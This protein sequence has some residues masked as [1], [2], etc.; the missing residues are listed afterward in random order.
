MPEY[1]GN[2]SAVERSGNPLSRFRRVFLGDKAFYSRVAAIV[3]PV[4]IQSSVT[5][6]VNLLDN[7]MVGQLGT[8][9]VSGVAIA[10]QLVFLYSLIIFGALSGPS[11]YG[12]QFYGAKNLDGYRDCFRLK[13]W[14]SFILFA[15]YL[16]VVLLF[17][18]PLIRLFLRGDGDPALAGSILEYSKDYLMWI[19]PALLPFALS[20]SYASTLREAGE[21]MLPMRASLAAVLVNLVFNYLLIFG[22]LGFPELGVKGAAIATMLARVVELVIIAAAAHRKKRYPYLKGLYKRLLVPASLVGSVMSTSAPLILNE[23]LWAL[24]IT[25]LNQIYSM[26]ALHVLAAISIASTIANLFNVFYVSIGNAVAVMVGQAL[27]AGRMDRA[28]SYAWKLIFLATAMCL[29][30]GGIMAALSPVFPQ[31]YNTEDKVRELV[32]GFILIS[33]ALMPAVAISHTA[34]YILRSGGSTVITFLYDAV[35]NWAVQVPLAFL[36]VKYTDFPILAVYAMAEG[37]RLF[38]SMLG[39]LMVRH[40]KWQQQIVA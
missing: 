5:N 3:I 18:E 24:A 11:I 26:R 36:L 8:A 9:Q 38:K 29:V 17:H 40:G 34:Y 16:G 33:S 21:T 2:R 13:L 6:F 1:A 20:M 35:F 28:R 32:T 7:I 14:L 23:A 37:A 31:F 22:E 19:L 25:A 30:I 15:L 39:L 12:A 4:I 10:N 27:G